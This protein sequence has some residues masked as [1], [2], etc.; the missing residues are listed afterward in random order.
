MKRQF[1]LYALFFAMAAL[2]VNAEEFRL[3]SL[4]GDQMVLQQQS[5]VPL[6]GWAP[7]GEKVTVLGS[8]TQK[9]VS[10]K[11]D[12]EGRWRVEL[13]TPPA[14]GP[15]TIRI[16]CGP[17]SKILDNILSGEVWICSGQSNMEWTMSRFSDAKED[18]AQATDSNLRLF[19]VPKN[20]SARPELDCPGGWESSNPETVK[21]FSATSY[22]FGREL[23]KRLNVPIGLINT[24]YGGSS[25]EA[26]MDWDVLSND[27]DF[28]PIVKRAR[29][30][31]AYQSDP[32]R[33]LQQYRNELARWK[34]EADEVDSILA[35]ILSGG[36][37]FD[38]SDWGQVQL[39]MLDVA[40]EPGGRMGGFWFVRRVDLPESWEGKPAW[41]DLGM[42]DDVDSIWMNE[43]PVTELARE[44]R[45]ERK[46]TYK[47]PAN[48]IRSGE[49]RIAVRAIRDV[50]MKD[51]AGGGAQL[52]LEGGM[53]SES[54]L[55]AGTWSRKKAFD[56]WELPTVPIRP[57]DPTHQ[58]ATI[59]YNAMLSPVLPY[60]MR[61][62]I[63]YQGETNVPRAW[64]YRK[65]F[66]AM[67]QEWRT[68]WNQGEFPFYFVQIAPYQYKGNPE[69]AA[70]ELREAQMIALKVPQ[71]G[72]AI[73]MDI[74][75]P[76]NIHPLHKNRV[77]ERLALLAMANTYGQDNLVHSGP[78]YR[79]MTVE[80]DRIRLYFDHV[81]GGLVAKGG[82]LSHFLLA[83]KDRRFVQAEAVI[84]GETILVSAPGVLDPVA[85]RYGWSNDAQPNLFNREG[86]PASSFRTDDWPGATFDT[87]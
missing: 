50:T 38:L 69:T 86:L 76:T 42:L 63:W 82:P 30:Q 53:D 46:W 35:S 5:K 12:S 3:P 6:W 23:R 29:T 34:A 56:L 61:G 52:G 47:V 41:L 84:D 43:V 2:S 44:N 77:G 45:R 17:A 39:P 55:L 10:S 74:G 85:V 21:T 24:S 18:I 66:P 64:Q 11:S 59:L 33:T 81:G 9:A 87:R 71:T 16:Q 75:D 8:W 58:T 37:Y 4:I 83:G 51:I 70:A 25:L 78:L 73:T 54:I 32:E 48:A 14:G 79:S 13:K 20:R 40:E 15:F 62:V 22:Y 19:T 67:I 49:N 65:L 60:G 1:L 31:F 7:A 80:G 72:M 57:S 27:P 36:R 28:A 26:W 68:L